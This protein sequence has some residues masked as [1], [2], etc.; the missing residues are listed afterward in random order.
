MKYKKNVKF[1]LSKYIKLKSKLSLK[2]S[3]LENSPIFKRI[4]QR[5][6]RMNCN[7]EQNNVVIPPMLSR[8]LDLLPEPYCIRTP[9]SPIIYANL[10]FAKLAS[11]RSVSDIIDRFDYEIPSCLFEN[12]DLCEE[13]RIQDR[14][15]LSD[16]KSQVMLEVHPNAIDY[17]Y[18]CRKI[19]F[20]NND[21]Q[22]IGAVH[23]IKYL[24]IFTPNDFIRGKF[25]GSLLLNRP[26]D[27]FTEKEC[28]IIFFRLQGM[29]TKEISKIIN[30][31]KRTIENRLSAMYLKAG[32]NHLDDFSEFCEKIN[33][34]R[35]IPK[36]IISY[37][38]IGFD[39]DHEQEI[40]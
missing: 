5:R 7:N 15:I 25:P 4:L 17:P 30:L 28:E 38:K 22:C 20:Y 14:K 16:R 6:H 24:E 18:I 34:H 9:D 11:L 23:S 2:F 26:N 33:L 12:A 35:Y 27:F 32:V 1:D 13:W 19:P 29:S 21:H 37:S 3:F 31:S 10:A 40:I 39:K 8:M 36:R